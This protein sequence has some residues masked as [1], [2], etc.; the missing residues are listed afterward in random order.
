[1]FFTT[2]EVSHDIQNRKGKE[3]ERKI[4]VKYTSTII[5][6]TADYNLAV[7]SRSSTFPPPSMGRISVPSLPKTVYPVASTS[8][9]D[10]ESAALDL[11]SFFERGR[12]KTLVLTGAGVSTDS[13][14]RAYRGD[15]GVRACLLYLDV[16]KLIL[17]SQTYTINRNFR[18]F[19][20]RTDS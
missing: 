9:V 2:V 13:G 19:V 15:R 12:G 7:T 18:E 11:A 1:V 17:E 8:K 10:I 4:R 6:I 16:A 3:G 14:I 20:P 5:A